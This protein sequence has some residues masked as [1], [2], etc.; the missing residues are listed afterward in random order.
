MPVTH[1]ACPPKIHDAVVT[2]W[3]QAQWEPREARIVGTEGSE[4]NL[5]LDG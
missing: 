2:Q 3:K 4:E 1:L 5:G